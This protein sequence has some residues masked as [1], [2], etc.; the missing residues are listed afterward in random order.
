[1]CICMYVHTLYVYWCKIYMHKHFD[2]TNA[3][4]RTHFAFAFA[5]LAVA[6]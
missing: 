3:E 1:M 4:I 2:C 5:L 6:V